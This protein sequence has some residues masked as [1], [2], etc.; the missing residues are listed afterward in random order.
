MCFGPIFVCFQV[1]PEM[2]LKMCPRHQ[3][4]S[5]PQKSCGRGE[6]PTLKSKVVGT[7][8]KWQSQSVLWLLFL[9]VNLALWPNLLVLFRILFLKKTGYSLT[10]WTF[11]CTY[12]NLQQINCEMECCFG[13]NFAPIL[14]KFTWNW[15]K[16]T[17]WNFSHQRENESGSR[18]EPCFM[19]LWLCF[20]APNPTVF[21]CLF[22]GNSTLGR[23][24]HSYRK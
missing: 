12:F 2:H 20:L 11:E 10:L 6:K 13:G 17:L 4:H 22:I 8:F 7:I 18:Q 3:V 23:G 1:V 9:F 21:F 16:E 19:I 15:V 24:A 5:W 14:I